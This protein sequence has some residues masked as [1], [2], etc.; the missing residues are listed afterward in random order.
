MFYIGIDNGTSGGIA[1]IDGDSGTVLKLELMPV[2]DIGSTTFIDEEKLKEIIEYSPCHIIF[3]QGQK[4][5]LF[6]TKGNFS[7]GYSFGVVNTVIRMLKKPHTLVN[8]QTWQKA[9]FQDVRGLMKSKANP[10]GMSTK[11]A[12]FE[13][14]KRLYPE[15]SLLPTPRSKKPHDGLAD[16]LLMAVYGRRQN[17]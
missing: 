7:N 16:A 11:D 1:I 5:P 17:F 12:S 3:E 10:K 13:M 6:G 14:C 9:L 4:N 8:P 15:I 2:Y